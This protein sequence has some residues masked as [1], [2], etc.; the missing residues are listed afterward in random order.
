MYAEN[1]LTPLSLI[2]VLALSLAIW[3]WSQNPDHSSAAYA[4]SGTGALVGE[5]TADDTNELLNC[6]LGKK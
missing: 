1:R 4:A 5:E 3:S 6:F 2:G